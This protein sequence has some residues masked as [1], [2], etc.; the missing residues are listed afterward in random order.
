M[1]LVTV[2]PANNRKL[3][4]VCKEHAR[5]WIEE[6]TGIAREYVCNDISSYEIGSLELT[7]TTEN[8]EC[9]WC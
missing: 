9:E 8:K 6:M 4:F 7:Y 2:P 1:Y 3:G 5:D